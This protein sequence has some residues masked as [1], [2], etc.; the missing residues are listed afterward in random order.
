MFFGSIMTAAIV[1]LV[2]GEGWLVCKGYFGSGGQMRG[3]GFGTLMAVFVVAGC[4][5]L[6]A[7]ARAKGLNPSGWLMGAGAV[8][9]VM[10]PFW[11]PG[12][13]GILAAG[14]VLMGAV[15]AGGV[16]QA[17]RQ[18][19]EKTLGNLG[20]L[21]LGMVYLGFG[22]WFIVGLRLLGEQQ[23]GVWGQ[24]RVVLLFLACV[25]C[26]DIGAYF[27]GRFLGRHKMVPSISPGKTWEGFG[28][29][30]GLAV[31]AASIF[32]GFFDIINYW[33]TILF[34][35]VMAVSGQLGDLLE[36]MLKRDAGSK[37]SAK[38]VPEFGGIL[39][40]I[41]SPI[42]AAPIAYFLLNLYGNL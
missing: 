12:K 1:L 4:R 5:E 40:I 21:C 3:V 41:D 27:T 32:A 15:M 6:V 36:S 26:S 8:M 7:I 22:G 24:T 10:Q 29:G 17:K 2:L 28:G 16:V 9:I 25:K 38:L 33:E 18:G 31:I 34:G 14:A 13:W 42:I 11:T 30:I 37:D 19:T 35:I 39:D 23:A 20:S